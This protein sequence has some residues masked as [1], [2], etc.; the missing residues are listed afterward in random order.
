MDFKKCRIL[1]AIISLF[2]LIKIVFLL[3]YHLPIWD[4]AV[5]LGTGKYIYSL[6]NSGLWEDFRP[7]GFPLVIGTLWKLG[8]SY[9]S[10]AEVVSV[11]FAAGT[12]ALVY[13]IAEMLFGRK[14]AV[15]SAL[16]TATFPL[17]FLY[18][19]YIL[20]EIPSTFFALLAVYLYLRNKIVF[21][22]IS[23][24]IAFLF[25]FTQGLMA[26]GFVL[27]FAYELLK[28][29]K[30]KE[31]AKKTALFCASFFAAVLP[32]LLLNYVLYRKYTS[33]LFDAIFRPFILASW[34]QYNP[35]ESIQ[36]AGI[37]ALL[38][39]LFFYFI[40]I[41]KNNFLLI[42]FVIGAI[43]I[44]KKGESK[45]A[46]LVALLLAYFAYFT[47]IPNKQDRFLLTFFPFIAILAGYALFFLLQ[48]YKG[49]SLAWPLMLIMLLSGAFAVIVD[50]NYFFWRAAHKEGIVDEMYG[51]IDANDVPEPIL[52]TDPVFAAYTD[53]KLV[54][55]YYSIDLGINIYNSYNESPATIVYS[56]SA[57]YCGKDI[58]CMQHKGYLESR[59]KE[60]EVVFSGT[61]YETQD[62]YI[63][64]KA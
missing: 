13:L 25:K 16:L 43:L 33:T 5:Y 2:L 9:I 57:F 49:T 17:F 54:P 58:E 50:S 35:A 39:N 1:I 34:H 61:F 28:D 38:Q 30:I 11:L 64:K 20:T 15:I 52:I 26:A 60:N 27:F 51:F 32:Y 3:K 53:K 36:G 55:Y 29:K 12:V 37:T 45:K 47:Y 46:L 22:G 56:P 40:T 14:V 6:G 7:I 24:G 19:S 4:E 23:S 44:M 63:Y 8:I 62:Y 41:L 10:A 31:T 21:A 48:K 59:L 42:V 18:A